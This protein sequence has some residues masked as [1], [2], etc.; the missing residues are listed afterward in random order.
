MNSVFTTNNNNYNLLTKTTVPNIVSKTNGIIYNGSYYLIGGNIVTY[1]GDSKTWSSTPISI[2]GMTTIKNFAWNN[3]SYGIPKIQPLTIACGEGTNTLAYSPDGIYWIGLGKTI[4]SIRSNKALWNGVLWVAGGLGGYCIA[5]SYDGILWTGRATTILDE[6]YDIAWNG[7][8]FIA[9]GSGGAKAIMSADGITW[10]GIPSLA[11]L[12][13]GVINSVQWTGKIWLATGS[14]GNTSAYSSDGYIWQSTNPK[15]LIITDASNVFSD[16]NA[17]SSITA[18]SITPTYFATN[19]SDNSMNLTSSTEWR[20]NTN[21]YDASSGLYTGT[22]TTVYNTNLTA[23]GEWL[24]INAQTPLKIVYY[25]LSWYTDVSSSYFT[26]PD[27]WFLLGSNTDN[28]DWNLINYFNYNT[29]T[30]PVNISSNNFVIKLQNIYSN[31]SS[32]QYYRFVFPSLFPSGSQTFVRLSELDL[33]YEN[34]NSTTI[35]RYIKPIITPTHILYQTNIIPFSANTGKRIVYQ[36]TD[37]CGNYITNNTLNNGSI[38][39]SIINGSPNTFITSGCFDGENYVITPMSGNICYMNTQSLN[40][41]FNFDISVNSNVINRNISGNVYSSCFNGQRIV[42]GGTGGNV[43]TYSPIMNKNP[44]GNFVSSLNANSLFT[45]VYCVSSNSG[46]GPL[47]IPNR[48]YF[49]S[50]D[51]LMVVGPKYYN[52]SISSS[53]TISMNLNNYVPQKNISIPLSTIVYGNIGPIGSISISIG[54]IG[55]Y[56]N[57]DYGNY[58][59]I[60]YD[61][62][63]V[64]S[65]G[66]NGTNGANGIIGF[67]GIYGVQG[68]NGPQGTSG[69]K[70][71]LGLS[72]LRGLIGT[73]GPNGPKLK[74]PVDEKFWNIGANNVNTYSNIFISSSNTT[75]IFDNTLNINGNFKTNGIN[76]N[77]IQSNNTVTNNKFIVGKTINQIVPNANIVCDISGDVIINNKINI[78]NPSL[79]NLYSFDVSGVVYTRKLRINNSVITYLVPTNITSSTVTIDFNKSMVFYVDVGTTINSNFTCIL[80][81][82]N[83]YGNAS[84]LKIKLILDYANSLLNRYF[85]DKINRNGTLYN[86][87]YKQGNPSALFSNSIATNIYIQNITILFA[88]G[89][90]WNVM[91]DSEF[92]SS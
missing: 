31:T 40:T 47:Y 42:L 58:G 62:I 39:N 44:N 26:I 1:S 71:S 21:L 63:F 52:K 59:S 41:N 20:S 24:Q 4:F 51:K 38:Y 49:N 43:I 73:D 56:T 91:C 32:Y 17:A 11:Q 12:F 68:T 87:R 86:I 36:V 30:P 10:N 28:G 9:V 76:A 15:N 3:P 27:E 60:G 29:T 70:G 82:F 23:S 72:G 8:I 22:I 54:A 88:G 35:N 79:S 33:F 89:N 90:I 37:L 14:G 92:Y 77:N 61:S 46:Y 80:N 64:G 69:S 57:G 7:S 45:S 53:T 85:C 19:V 2:S 50:G 16:A 13:S 74:G 67:D 66:T 34:A 65:Q 25:H 18:S 81:N 6:V 48:L 84:V 78:N 75:T 5:S 83:F 55:P